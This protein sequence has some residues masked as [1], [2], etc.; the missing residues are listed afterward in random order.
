M[1]SA[2]YNLSGYYQPGGL[3]WLH[4]CANYFPSTGQFPKYFY[5]ASRQY[6][7]NIQEVQESLCSSDCIFSWVIH[8]YDAQSYGNISVLCKLTLVILNT[9]SNNCST[10]V[11]WNISRIWRGKKI[12]LFLIVPPIV[13]DFS[14]IRVGNVIE[15]CQGKQSYNLLC[16][17]LRASCVY[18]NIEL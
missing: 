8:P 13:C 7:L 4:Y 12:L 1:W 14:S 9:L 3:C 6:L 10:T 11:K 2:G 15:I 16:G 5:L 18:Q 17:T